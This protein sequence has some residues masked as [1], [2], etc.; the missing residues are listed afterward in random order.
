M[1]LVAR[2]APST[3]TASPPAGAVRR[4]VRSFQKSCHRLTGRGAPRDAAA[5]V[6]TIEYAVLAVG[7]AAFA[8]LLWAFAHTRNLALLLQMIFTQALHAPGGG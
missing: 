1:H 8:T 7:A 5:G 2:S 6:V 4:L 3:P